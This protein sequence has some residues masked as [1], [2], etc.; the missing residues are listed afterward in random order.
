MKPPLTSPLDE[1]NPGI[2]PEAQYRTLMER[3]PDALLIFG[4]D[5]E[6]YY[7]N[8]AALRMFGAE[9]ADQ[10]VGRPASDFAHPSYRRGAE[11]NVELWDD[12]NKEEHS[13]ELVA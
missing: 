2:D 5:F 6:I 8:P 11:R 3:M 1:P 13:A 12:L 10:L 9:R 4:L 7:A